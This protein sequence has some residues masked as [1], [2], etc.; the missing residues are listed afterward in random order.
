MNDSD[1]M[2]ANYLYETGSGRYASLDKYAVPGKWTAVES[3]PN[4]A[5]DT[6][7][8]LDDLIA[9]GMLGRRVVYSPNCRVVE[10]VPGA[11]YCG[12]N[13]GSVGE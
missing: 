12:G 5:V 10:Q 8:L 13:R 11:V 1:L 7:D 2:G 9:A 6:F 4:P 3:Q